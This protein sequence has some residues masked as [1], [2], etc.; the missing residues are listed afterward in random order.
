MAACA[1]IRDSARHSA[2]SRN[3]TSRGMTLVRARAQSFAIVT[4]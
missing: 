3:K 4:R 2:S 1:G